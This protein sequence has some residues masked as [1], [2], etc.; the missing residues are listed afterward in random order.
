[1]ESP[2]KNAPSTKSLTTDG[3]GFYRRE[4]EQTEG[5][6]GEEEFKP[7]KIRTTQERPTRGLREIRRMEPNAN[8]SASFAQKIFVEMKDFDR[9]QRTEHKDFNHGWTLMGT[10]FTGGNRSKRRVRKM[11]AEKFARP[12]QVSGM[13]HFTAETRRAR[14]AQRLCRRARRGRLCDSSRLCGLNRRSFWLRPA[15]LG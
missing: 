15:A 4:P 10:D 1:M 12:G 11:E 2:L 6:R 3:H 5:K 7:R 14:R 8:R 13:Q 9:V